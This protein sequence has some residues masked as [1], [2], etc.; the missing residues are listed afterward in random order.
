MFAE[1]QCFEAEEAVR[2]IDI[3]S[4]LLAVVSGDAAQVTRRA[5]VRSLS[6]LHKAELI[7]M[8]M[9]RLTMC[10]VVLN[11]WHAFHFCLVP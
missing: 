10:M 11:T 6:L 5:E 9:L 1:C 3:N 4:G 8:L 2:K 7:E